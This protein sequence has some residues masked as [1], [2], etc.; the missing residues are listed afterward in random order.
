MGWMVWI[1]TVMTVAGMLM[2]FWVIM[3]VMRARKAGLSEDQMKARLQ[4]MVAWNM[5]A[6]GLSALGLM[7]VIVGFALS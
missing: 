5:G 7:T 2:L 6:L 4:R 3:N 1:G